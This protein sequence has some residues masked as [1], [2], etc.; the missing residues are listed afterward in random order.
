MVITVNREQLLPALS[1]IGGIVEKKQTLPIL[2]NFLVQ[3]TDGKMLLTATDLEIEI[4][5]VSD[6]N[7]GE[8]LEPFT[9]P[10]RKFVDICKAL[11][12]DV[13]IKLTIDNDKV[14]IQARQARF[15]IATL[16]AQDYPSLEMIPAQDS[17][18]IESKVLKHLL[19]STAFSMANQDGRHYLNGTLLDLANNQLNCVATNGHRLAL[20]KYELESEH[21]EQQILLPRKIVYELIRLLEDSED[22][23]EVEFGVNF[24]RFKL[25][26]TLITT[27][28]I[29]GKFP[30]YQRVIPRNLDKTAI[31]NREQFR[32]ALFRASL[33][34]NEKYKG[35][36]LSFSTDKLLLESNNNDQEN[37]EEELEIDYKSDEISIGFNSDYLLNVITTLSCREVAIDL[38]DCL[39]SIVIRNP[40]DDNALYVI[41]PMRL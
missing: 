33:L 7:E 31:I 13:E 11:S 8:D 18:S 3:I 29:D 19:S 39:S 32:H 10:A 28:L 25:G 27:K 5:T 24:C 20:C 16:P 4:R 6:I 23:V 21:E 36:K 40:D 17:F 38:I 26:E 14:L 30:D 1:T 12:E 22:N 41:M 15:N 2:G 9:L 34:S 37:A 35:V